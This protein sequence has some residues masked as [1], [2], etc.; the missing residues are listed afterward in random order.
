MNLVSSW[1]R[2]ESEMRPSRMII[3]GPR[4]GW[5]NLGWGFQGVRLS[6]DWLVGS[7]RNRVV[8][9]ESWTQPEVTIFERWGPQFCRRTEIN[10]YAHS[11]RRSRDPAPRLYHHL[12]SPLLF[13]YPIPSLINN[14]EF[15]L[16]NSGKVNEAEWSLYSIS[17]KQVTQKGFVFW[18]PQVFHSS[19]S[20][21]RV[22]MSLA[23]SC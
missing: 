3:T 10:G 20:R 6:S 7:Y 2:Q 22:M 8:F 16:W 18:S 12:I 21:N 11:L 23:I 1:N 17:K 15:N 19:N 9:Q 14:S 13:L 4:K 5:Q